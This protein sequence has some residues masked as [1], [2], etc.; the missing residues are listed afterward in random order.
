MKRINKRFRCP[1]C[2]STLIKDHVILHLASGTR[3]GDVET[4]RRMSAKEGYKETMYCAKCEG[5]VKMKALIEGKF[6]VRDYSVA[7]VAVWIL[8]V[9]ALTRGLGAALWLSGLIVTAVLTCFY[10]L[11]EKRC[12]SRRIRKYNR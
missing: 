4:G 8:L 6:D 7:Y 11:V 10:F 3:F 12:V 9:V 2:G 1:S 5:P